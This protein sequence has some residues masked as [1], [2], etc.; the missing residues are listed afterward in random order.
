M[1]EAELALAYKNAPR[2]VKVGRVLMI[3]GSVLF[4]IMA[5]GNIVA[6]ILSLVNGH[7]DGHPLSDVG[8][9]MQTYALP[10]ISAFFILTGIGGLLFVFDAKNRFCSFATLGAVIMLVVIIVDTVLSIRTLVRDLAGINLD[11]NGEK[12]GALYAWISFIIGLLDIQ[13]SGGIYV[14]GWFKCKDFVGD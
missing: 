10:L 13:L 7:N 8:T 9:A 2:G 1:N 3:I 5:I 6:F 4:F 14:I 12:V 11:A